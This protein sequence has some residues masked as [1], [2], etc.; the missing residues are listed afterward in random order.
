MLLIKKILKII[1]REKLSKDPTVLLKF[2]KSKLK[3]KGA[4]NHTI[5]EQIIIFQILDQGHCQIK[6]SLKREQLSCLTK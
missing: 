3:Q 6:I 1:I 5:A 2:Q 4:L